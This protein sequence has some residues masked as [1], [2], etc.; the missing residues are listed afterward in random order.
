MGAFP[1][2]MLAS[3]SSGGTPALLSGG[4]N[5]GNMTGGGGLA[6]GFDGNTVQADGVGPQDA[7]G[8]TTDQT[9]GKNWGGST[10]TVSTCKIYPTTN[11]GL[12]NTGAGQFLVQE[13]S[14]GSAWTTIYTSATQV[15][16]AV[17]TI[18]ATTVSPTAKQ[19]HRV[20]FKTNGANASR[21]CEI[22]F[23]GV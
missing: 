17:T 11:V 18:T 19:Y 4:T 6:A 12:W 9:I 10:Y 2:V 21:C 16:P 1:A 14:D 5:I 23:Y 13:S 15:W 7:S 22:E 20:V 8:G 3:L